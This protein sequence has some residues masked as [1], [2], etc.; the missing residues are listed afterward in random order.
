MGRV[1]RPTAVPTAVG[2]HRGSLFFVRLMQAV[3]LGYAIAC[4][5]FLALSGFIMRSLSRT[6]GALGTETVLTRPQK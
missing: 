3:I 1:H 4:G 5:V 6:G 2:D